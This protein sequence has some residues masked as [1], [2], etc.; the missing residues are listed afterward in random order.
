MREER[1][2]KDKEKM[3]AAQLDSYAFQTIELGRRNRLGSSYV[4][5]DANSADAKLTLQ[6]LKSGG[7]AGKLVNEDYLAGQRARLIDPSGNTRSLSASPAN[8]ADMVA[9]KIPMD[10]PPA[11]ESVKGVIGQAVSLAARAANDPQ[12]N[13][14]KK[15]KAAV[16]SFVNETAQKILDDQFKLVKPGD[17][18]NVYQVP[19]PDRLLQNPELKATLLPLPITQKVIIP[20]LQANID[21][22]D[23]NTVWGLAMD[24]VQK[25]NL[26]YKE[27]LSLSMFYSR[28]AAVNLAAKQIGSVGLTPQ[29]GYNVPVTTD[30]TAMFSTQEPVDLT[31]ADDVGRAMNKYLSRSVGNAISLDQ[32]LSRI[33]SKSNAEG[34]K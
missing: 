10:L 6:L 22:S 9:R 23:P 14:D 8:F 11:M 28:A 18:T 2:L 7:D 20:A 19:T 4:P 25:G 12:G 24:A 31:K 27:A 13:L 33:K 17:K 32:G 26:S 1:R 30:P 5:T 16:D 34:A 15:N 29:R 3:D 21:L